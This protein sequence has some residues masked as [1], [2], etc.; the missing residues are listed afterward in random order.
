MTEPSPHAPAIAG[1]KV[2]LKVLAAVA[3]VAVLL[4]ILRSR[5]SGAATA[6]NTATSGSAGSNPSGTLGDAYTAMFTQLQSDNT[7]AISQ[8]LSDMQ[9]ANQAALAA[10]LAR[11][12][13]ST[14]AAVGAIQAALRRIPPSTVHNPITAKPGGGAGVPTAAG[15]YVTVRSGDTLGKIAASSHVPN[16]RTL[17]NSRTDPNI[18]RHPNLI[19]PGQKVWVP[20]Q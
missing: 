5:N 12:R 7:A 4:L 17:L 1:H 3:G 14:A 2:N 13:T 15:H 16:W 8:S 20:A 19:E 6:G 10:Q 9:K 11:D 18:N